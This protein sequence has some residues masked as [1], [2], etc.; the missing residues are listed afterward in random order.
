MKKSI[1]IN[2]KASV[3]SVVLKFIY[4]TNKIIVKGEENYMKID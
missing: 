1:S 4:G 2:V 3:L